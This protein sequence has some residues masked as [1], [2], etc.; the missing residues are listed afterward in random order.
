LIVIDSSALVEIALD[1]HRAE[2][3]VRQL[4]EAERVLLSAGTL[5][6]TLIV[7]AGRGAAEAADTLFAAFDFEVVPVTERRARAAAE[8]YRRYGKGWHAAGLN[9]G[10]CFAYALAKEHDCP[11]LFIGEDFAK[12]DVKPAIA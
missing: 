9:F 11:L 1:A 12:T 10:D 7:A 8:A 5:M 4:T 3:C 2:D 6:E